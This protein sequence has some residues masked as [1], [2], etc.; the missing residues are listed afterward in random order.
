MKTIKIIRNDII[1]DSNFGRIEHVY[2]EYK[3]VNPI[4][5][6]HDAGEIVEIVDIAEVKPEEADRVNALLNEWH[7]RI[8]RAIRRHNGEEKMENPWA[9]YLKI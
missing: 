6:D 1:T 8:D 9:E 3:D 7:K 4:N 5:Y 2:D